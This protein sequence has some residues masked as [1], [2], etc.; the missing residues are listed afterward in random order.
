MFTLDETQP[1]IFDTLN[2]SNDL[3]IPTPVIMSNSTRSSGDVDG[4]LARLSQNE[5]QLE[6]RRNENRASARRTPLV[7]LA[8]IAR[9]ASHPQ[10]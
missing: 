6:E 4:Y 10:L 8:W 3:S 5:G 7:P 2:E 1:I 9:A